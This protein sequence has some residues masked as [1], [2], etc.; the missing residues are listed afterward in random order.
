M[1]VL[2]AG[3]AFPQSDESL[4][5]YNNHSGDNPVLCDLGRD[6]QTLHPAELAQV[7][8]HHHQPAAARLA[9]D[10][11]VVGT[12]HRAP[13]LQARS[14]LGRVRRRV[15]VEGQH[16]QPGHEAL[17][18]APHLGGPGRALR[19]VEQLVEHH[20][21]GAERL[22][23]RVETPPQAGRAI[24]QHPDAQV[25]VEQVAQRHSAS[26]SC[27]AGCWR[28]SRSTPGPAKKSSHSASAGAMT[29]RGPSRRITTSRTPSPKAT[30]LGRRTAWERLDRNRVVRAGMLFSVYIRAVY[31]FWIARSK[32]RLGRTPYL[33]RGSIVR[34]RQSAALALPDVLPDPARGV[35]APEVGRS[36]IAQRDLGGAVPGLA[37]DLG[38]V[39]ALLAGGGGQ[40]CAQRVPREALPPLQ[41]GRP[42]RPLHQPPHRLVRQR[43]GGE[44]ARLAHPHEQRPPGIRPAAGNVGHLLPEAQ[45]SLQGCQRAAARLG[46][47]GPDGDLLPGAAL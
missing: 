12:D 11:Q 30:P 1:P 31:L 43:G 15:T 14:D 46:R 33:S 27:I 34:E 25:G 5:S 6:S 37:H 10:H 8:R 7:A 36:Q 13:P 28:S 23:L 17:H 40:P 45:P 19:P 38:E 41:P 42:R 35:V 9:G 21:R 3:R 4:M 16:A 2:R 39:G 29:R 47:I 20:V 18:L 44:P 32:L 22:G 24:A 26:R